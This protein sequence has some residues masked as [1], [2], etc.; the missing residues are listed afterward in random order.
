M[1]SIP[2]RTA[3]FAPSLP[4]S[5]ASGL[6]RLVF[7]SSTM[8]LRTSCVNLRVG[9]LLGN[10]FLQADY[11]VS[12]PISRIHR[13]EVRVGVAEAGEECVISKTDGFGAGGNDC[14]CPDTGIFSVCKYNQAGTCQC[15][16]LAIEHSRG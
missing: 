2:A 13:R 1:E 4:F 8:A 11:C 15:A 6:H 9:R 16:A 3:R 7:A 12:F 5:V 10:D 14:L